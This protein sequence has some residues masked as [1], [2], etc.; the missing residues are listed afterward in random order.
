MVIP[1]VD[2]LHAFDEPQDEYA[3]DADPLYTGPDIEATPPDVVEYGDGQDGADFDNAPKTQS[4]LHETLLA[5]A[6]AVR[7]AEEDLSIPF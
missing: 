3:P 7:K 1:H 5:K 2:A 4:A 6:A